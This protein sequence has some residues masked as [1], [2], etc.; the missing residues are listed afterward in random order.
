LILWA[1]GTAILATAT[2][3][4]GSGVNRRSTYNRIREE[5]T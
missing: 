5:L 4:L 3:F 2:L 1:G